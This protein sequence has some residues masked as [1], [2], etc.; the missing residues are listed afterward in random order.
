MNRF[1]VVSN[2][3]PVKV[4]KQGK[5]ICFQSSAGG[6]ATGMKSLADTYSYRWLGWPGVAREQ[7]SSAQ[8][9]EVVDTL[10]QQNCLPVFLSQRDVEDYYHGFANR[11]IWPLF[12]YFPQ[13]TVYEDRCW[14]S[15]RDVNERFC[16]EVAAIAGPDD[17]IWIHDYQLMLLPQ[18]IRERIPGALIGFFLHI[19]FP[20]YEI[21]RLLPWRDDIVRG[22]LGADLVG[23]HTYD[24]VR[25]FLSSVCRLTGAEHTLGDLHVADR[26]VKVDAFPMGIDYE[27][28]SGAVG[29]EEVKREIENNRREMGSCRIIFSVDRLDYTKGI[30]QRLEAFDAFL[31][32][33]PEYKGKVRFILL[34]IP[35]RTSVD[36]YQMLKEQ[37][38]GLIGKINGS[39]GLLGWTPVLYLY[40]SIPFEKLVALYHQADVALITPLRDGM[41]LVA[42]ECI[43][44]K[45]HGRGVL[46]LSEMAGAASEMGEALIVNPNDKEKI[47]QAIK[48]ALEMPPSEQIER[49]RSMQQRLG[50]YTV[51]RWA[52]D[53]LD[54][55][56]EIQKKQRDLSVRKLSDALRDRLL[57]DYA[58]AA[59]RLFFLDYDGT[60]VDFVDRPEKAEPDSALLD[61]LRALA[62]DGRNEIIIISGRD[63][64]TL[65]RWLGALPVTLI[66][67]HGAWVR[68]KNGSWRVIGPL[69]N[70]W[71]DIIRPIMELFV[72]R[73][74]GASVEE[75]N[76][77]LAWHC[78]K[79]DPE[80]ARV[81][82]QELKAAIANFV[83]N[84]EIGVYE[85][86]KILEVKNLSVN[87]GHMTKLWLGKSHWGFILAAGDDYT[88]EDMFDVLGPQAY[89][90][91]VRPGISKAKYTV[92]AVADVRDLLR[93]MSQAAV[94]AGGGCAIQHLEHPAG[95]SKKRNVRREQG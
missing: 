81:R 69:R 71:K 40:R 95:S 44:A 4:S 51:A 76:F 92:D 91:K 64:T 29:R 27:K 41:N 86:N 52:H 48:V 47:V 9:A 77:A 79:S 74:P 14:Q 8:T 61:G 60:L 53:F 17:R 10:A 80:L 24:Y 88:D 19:P 34:A 3:L 90:I 66:A 38:D 21:F 68:P 49:N 62:A 65:T 32:R 78:R 63:K 13:N 58:A 54:G 50:R 70:D 84:L 7:L 12:H 18:M 20:S 67:E 28:F 16:D 55:L 59:S 2:R 83:E 73:T 56:G 6:L 33:Y 93:R 30:L 39:H 75:K 25:H 89:S 43:A 45:C 72:D 31:T 22:I 82:T 23:F 87:K 15:Y 57:R 94:P 46:I 37:L 5:S 35:S 1:I 11:T 42:K 36:H 26:L 85:G